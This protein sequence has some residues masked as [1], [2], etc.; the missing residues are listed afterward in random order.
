MTQPLWLQAWVGW[1]V[2]VNF[3]GGL[4]F[5]RRAEAKWVLG[6]IISAGLLMELLYSQFGYQRILG[7]AHVVFWTPLLVY[8][9]GRCSA[10]NISR[11]SGKWLAVVF[12]TNLTSLIIDYVDVARYLSGERL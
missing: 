2:L 4:V 11:L 7:L 10:W 1:M 12:V 8:L 5:I 3:V 9:W 6:A